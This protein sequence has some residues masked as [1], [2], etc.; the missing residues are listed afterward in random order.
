MSGTVRT[1]PE[2]RRRVEIGTY[3]HFYKKYDKMFYKKFSL[4][5]VS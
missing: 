3:T 5:N 4:K 1:G 2:G